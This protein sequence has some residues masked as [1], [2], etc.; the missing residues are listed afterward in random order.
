MGLS[1]SDLPKSAVFTSKLPSDPDFP[2]PTDSHG[3]PRS[4]LGPRRVKAAL[5]T[6]VR[7]EKQREPELLAVSPAALRDLGLRQGEEQTELF[8]EVVSGN[9]ML[10]WDEETRTGDLYPW[11]QCYG[12]WPRSLPHPLLSVPATRRWMLKSVAGWQLHVNPVDRN[13]L[14]CPC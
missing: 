13:V 5:Y 11:A 6:Y 10:G 9:R 3:A 7:P 1:L 8:K 2:T 12:G 4:R 14:P